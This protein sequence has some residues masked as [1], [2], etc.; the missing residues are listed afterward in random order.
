MNK[1]NFAFLLIIGG[2]V[3]SCGDTAEKVETKE[4]TPQAESTAQP[5]SARDE[6]KIEGSVEEGLSE[7]QKKAVEKIKNK[8]IKNKKRETKERN[9]T[10]KTNKTK[11]DAFTFNGIVKMT[12]IL[13]GLL[14]SETV[15][16]DMY[17]STGALLNKDL[18]T[19]SRNCTMKGEARDKLD[20][21]LVPMGNLVKDLN[22]KDEA[23]C[24]KALEGLVAQIIILNKTFTK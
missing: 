8:K 11:L 18:A 4:V 2:M 15:T 19:I 9:E 14:E 7:A 12:R 20:N 3:F 21:V 23:G 17:R 6:I 5:Q 13:R 22:E 24:A 10:N 16:L 1:M